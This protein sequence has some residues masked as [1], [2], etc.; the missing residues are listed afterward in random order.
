MSG[1]TLLLLF[2]LLLSDDFCNNSLNTGL[3]YHLGDVTS[4]DDAKLDILLRL[5]DLEKSLN[6][7][8]HGGLLVHAI[9][10]LAF[11]ELAKLLGLLTDSGCLPLA[12]CT[13]WLSLVELGLA[14]EETS[15][16]S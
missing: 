8:P 12:E 6:C 2:G 14:I 11:Q 15:D 13:R 3:R 5:N 4:L 9:S 7:K 16:E 10:V 1:S